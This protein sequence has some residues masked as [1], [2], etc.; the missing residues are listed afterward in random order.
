MTG[1]TV[2]FY[3]NAPDFGGKDEGSPSSAPSLSRSRKGW[4][5]A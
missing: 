1:D 4:L 3:S 2:A 5:Q